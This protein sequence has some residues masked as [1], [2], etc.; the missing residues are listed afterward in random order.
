MGSEGARA[1]QARSA[2]HSAALRSVGF[3]RM[4]VYGQGRIVVAFGGGAVDWVGKAV[5]EAE[6]E[7]AEAEA[8]ARAVEE[9][10]TTPTSAEAGGS[11]GSMS[12]WR[13]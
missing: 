7:A 10:G 12:L 9:G 8:A 1:G 11:G 13:M 2:S 4:S 6:P 5:S 3:V